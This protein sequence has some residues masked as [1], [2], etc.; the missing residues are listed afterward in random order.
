MKELITTLLVLV[1]LAGVNVHHAK[2]QDSS[3]IFSTE[4]TS[5]LDNILIALYE[6]ISGEKGEERN[7]ER[8]LNLFHEKA[9][10]IPTRKSPEGKTFLTHM[11]PREY[12][13][14]SGGY[15]VENGF[16][17]N[18]ISRKEEHFGSLTHVW[19]TYESRHSKSDAE[20]FARGINSIQLMFDDN[21]WWVVSIYWTAETADNPIPQIYLEH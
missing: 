6:V 21:R 7:W 1:F 15:L 4:D 20:P 17:E 2:A 8:F 9:V 19:S 11:T 12:M 13:E 14:T 16:F 10:L 3:S 5:S 18:E